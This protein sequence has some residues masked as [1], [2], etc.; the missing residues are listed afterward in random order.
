MRGDYHS[1]LAPKM[2][3]FE[4]SERALPNGLSHPTRDPATQQEYGRDRIVLSAS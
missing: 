2:F 4:Q 1:G 3:E